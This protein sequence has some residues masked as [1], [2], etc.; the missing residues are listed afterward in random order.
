MTDIRNGMKSISGND[1]TPALI[2]RITGIA[3]DFD[4]PKNDAMF[5]ILVMLDQYH[6]AFSELPN[7]VNEAVNNAAKVAERTANLI[8]ND[9]S[10]KVQKV[11]AES[12][13]PLAT[14]AFDKGVKKYIDRIDS[15]A[16]DSAKNKAIP[17]A[18]G[19]AAAV[20]CFGVAVGWAAGAWS[21][22]D[23]DAALIASAAVA[24][25]TVVA[26]LAQKDAEHAAALAGTLKVHAETIARLQA[27][28]NAVID[29]LTAASR[30]AGTAE[31]Q[32]AYK[33]FTVGGGNIA[34]KCQ[35]ENWTL[36]KTAK[37]E[38]LCMPQHSSF[39]GWK[40]GNFGW[41]IP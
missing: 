13:E 41:L 22:S 19:A 26:Q 32:L 11:V 15:E 37:G 4:I 34:A 2:A 23:S 25:K 3:H 27:D 6:G 38:K 30:W 40:D 16:N 10:K 33:F 5:P 29:N 8:V 31:G 35:G 14:A 28:Q 12:L 9:A 24:Q 39:F 17:I 18:I 20:L 36:G 21:R 7:K 1:P